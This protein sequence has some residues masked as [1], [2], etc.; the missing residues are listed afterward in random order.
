[1]T[2]TIKFI[3][4][5]ILI[6]I[7]IFN[8]N[9]QES[10]IISVNETST[11]A[12]KVE[13][14]T[15]PAKKQSSKDDNSW[16]GFYVGGFGGYTNDR[17]AANVSTISSSAIGNPPVLAG[18]AKDGSQKINSKGFS[19]GGTFGYNYQKGKFFVGGEV[20]FSSDKVNKTVSATTLYNSE[21]PASAINSKTITQT[22]KSDWRFTAR[23]RIGVAFN[24]AVVYVT[25]GLSVTNIKYNGSYSD[26]ITGGGIA[27]ES[28][29]FAKTK[30]GT[31]V[32]AGVEFKV[33]SKWSIKGEYLFTQFGRISATSSNLTIGD[34]GFGG[35]PVPQQVFTHS[36]DLKSHS[37][38][39]GINYRF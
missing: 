36:T 6:S 27:K 3:A 19:G 2:N 26:K 11:T 28:S 4:I 20:D 5:A 12:E 37:V 7:G 8:V 29:S 10:T 39:F 13:K 35:D 22:V 30:A 33:A 32:G 1:M 9:A 25:G 23:P 21:F 24:K 31:S 15:E 14:K 34:V 38:R 16:T 18:I 17:A